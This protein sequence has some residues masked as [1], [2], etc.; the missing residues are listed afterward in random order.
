MYVKYNL[1]F[2][3]KCS[4]KINNT[5]TLVTFDVKSLYASVPHNYGL[6]AISFWIEKDPDLL[7]FR[8]SKGFLLESIKIILE[9]SNCTSNDE[10]YRQIS[11]TAMGTIF[12][13]TYA[14]L[15]MGYFEVQFYHICELKWGEE[16]QEFFSKNSRR[17]FDD[18]QTPLY[19]NK[20]NL[21]SY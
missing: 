17:F 18:R 13:P 14:T 16:F 1:D 2:W 8:F 10:F 15:T 11:G 6:E 19:K 7:R 3:R 4:R 9:N 5:I 12:A 20:V 21:R